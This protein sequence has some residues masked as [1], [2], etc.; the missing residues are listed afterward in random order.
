[1]NCR[2]CIIQSSGFAAAQALLL[3]DA[4]LAGSELLPGVHRPGIACVIPALHGPV[5]MCDVGA[6]PEPRATH[7]AQYGVMAE[8]YAK[9]VLGIESP[10][11]SL[12]YIGSEESKGTGGGPADGRQ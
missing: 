9:K 7:L 4:L 1:M 10:R 11:V 5:V 2:R 3:K 12:M 8:A 6:N